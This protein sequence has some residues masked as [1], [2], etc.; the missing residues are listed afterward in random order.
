MLVL[1]FQVFDKGSI[2]DSEG[3]E[4]DFKNTVILMTSNVGTDTIL[5]LCADPDT[6]PGPE[7]LA[8]A[9]R[10]DL[11]EAKNAQGVQ[12]FKQAFLGR[13]IVVPYYPISD[14]IMRQIIKLQLGRIGK[15]MRDN[16]NAV[17]SYDD[18]LIE[19][20]AGRCKE[21]Q[22][23]ARNVD[24]I[25]TRSLLPEISQ[26]V[27]ARMAQGQTLSSVHVGVDDSGAFKYDIK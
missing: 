24:H 18:N 8:E 17:F 9:V 10:P 11:L 15:R 21:V 13:T 26:E 2:E 14:D 7:A 16:H 4:I 22:S 20:I 25:L 23:G 12:T 1:F 6:M 19:S 27:L 5:K 3:R